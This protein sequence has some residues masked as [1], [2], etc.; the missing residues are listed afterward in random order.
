MNCLRG[1][2]VLRLGNE[3]SNNMFGTCDDPKGHLVL[4]KTYIFLKHV[5]ACCEIL[6]LLLKDVF[7]R[8]KRSIKIGTRRK[9]NL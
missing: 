6:V 2:S 3:Y 9:A 5:E 4:N 8:L 1:S 7:F